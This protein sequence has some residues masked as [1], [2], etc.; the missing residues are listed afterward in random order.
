[1]KLVHVYFDFQG[2]TKEAF[3]YYEYMFRTRTIATEPWGPPFGMSTDELGIRWM[4]SLE[5]AA[6]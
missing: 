5:H 2:T 4:P 3:A 1:M 6:H